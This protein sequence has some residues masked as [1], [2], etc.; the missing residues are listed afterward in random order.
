MRREFVCARITQMNDVDIARFEFD[1]DTTWTSFLLDAD[2]NIYSRYGGRDENV[3]E[4]RMSKES[5]LQTMREVLDVHAQRRT[6][7]EMA[8]AALVHPGPPEESRPEDIPLLRDNHEGCIHCHQVQEYRLLQAAHDGVFNRRLL[9]GYPLPEG[10]GLRF[11][12]DH[13]HRIEQVEERTPAARAGLRKGDIVTRVNDVPIHSEYDFRWA[14]HRAPDET[15]LRITVERGK[16]GVDAEPLIV[17]VVPTGNW[18]QTELGWR[19][20]LRSVP[21]PL[22]MLGYALGKEE[23][24]TAGL[25]PDRLAIKVLS[26]RGKG[27]AQNV[28]LEKGDLIIGIAGR[29]D[30]RSY[31]QFKSDL[32]RLYEPGDQVRLHVL[33]GERELDLTGQFPDWHTTDTSVP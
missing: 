24:R 31:D 30:A 1:Y 19:K 14:L 18:R 27:L 32:L 4:G 3:A 12:R 20:S 13:G 28:G 6:L 2:L 5:L 33:R 17:E 15:V 29:S 9:F 22:G 21:F 26:V 25:P 23:T 16:E 8:A 7:K 10:L 11:A